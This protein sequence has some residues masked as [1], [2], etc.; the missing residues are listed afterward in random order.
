MHDFKIWAPRTR[1]MTLKLKS[2]ELQMRGPDCEGWWHLEVAEAVHGTEYGFSIDDDPAVYPD[3]RSL[4]QPDGVHEM[5][6]VYDQ[7]AFT[8]NDA[9]FEAKP[10]PQSVIYEIHIGTFTPEGTLDSA[11]D[12]LDYLTDLGVTHLE[13]MPVAAFAG[14]RGWGYDGV[15]LFAVHELYGG[16]DALKRFVNAAHGKGLSILLDVVYNHF[17]PVGNYTGKFGP[18]LTDAHKTP[19]GCAVNLEE[20]GSREVRRFFS[21]NALMWLSDFHIDG[22]RL[23]AVHALIDRSAI[24]F[25]E[26][27]AKEVEGLGKSQRRRLVLIA[28][29]DLNDP[30]M[31]TERDAG[32]LGMDAQWNDDFHHALFTVL[33]PGPTEGYY[34]DFGEL[35]QL[36]KALEQTFVYD[37]IFSRYRNRIHGRPASDLPQSKFVGFIQNHDQIGNRAVGDRIAQIVGIDRAKM[38]AAILLIGPFIPLLFQGEEWAA[39]TP[40]QYFADHED[41]EMAKSVSEGRKMEF[42]AFGWEPETIPDPEARE[43]F[44]NSKLDWTEISLAGHAQ[45][46][47]WYRELIHLRNG[48]A[49]LW[50]ARPGA[51]RVS[52]SEAGKWF[53]LSR[54]EFHLICNLSAEKRRVTAPD[55]ASSLVLSSR[56]GVEADDNWVSLPGESVAIF[57]R[58]QQ[59]STF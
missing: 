56:K 2:A 18:Y 19:W 39:D 25:L 30:R 31:V 27:L 7:S 46:L 37:G 53:T 29:S 8:W 44:M 23:D 17:G 45:M 52:F 15:A 49:S 50:E 35:E 33:N 24:H 38:A 11:I 55:D 43:T 54:G 13:L 57:R 47:E 9:E 20:G 5:S 34:T 59:P 40:F 28:E 21:D 22:L 4:W 16:P 42:L 10:L 14:D 12:R 6:R 51:S 26:Q 58:N 3:P 48:S 36:A 41:P 1:S 32:G